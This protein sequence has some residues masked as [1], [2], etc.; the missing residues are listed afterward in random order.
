MQNTIRSRK[1]AGSSHLANSFLGPLV[2]MCCA[3]NLEIRRQAICA[4]ATLAPNEHRA[5][6]AALENLQGRSILHDVLHYTHLPYSL[7][8]RREAI[9]GLANLCAHQGTHSVLMEEDLLPA[10][11]QLTQEESLP[12]KHVTSCLKELCGN[13]EAASAMLDKGVLPELLRLV[14]MAE[15]VV[16][17][18]ALQALVALSFEPK[19]I[20]PLKQGGGLRIAHEMLSSRGD[21]ALCRQGATLACNLALHPQE[22]RQLVASDAP[23]LG[24]MLEALRQPQPCEDVELALALAT[25]CME[26][27]LQPQLCKVKYV[28]RVGLRGS[29]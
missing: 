21:K 8:Q 5:A 16:K 14:S 27:E 25:L 13:P 6:V 22:R 2:P 12:L 23:L 15:K 18:M 20:A 4:L 28:R 7:L 11:L 29:E 26:R 24:S 9:S 10:V 19:S 1:R 3:S 17:R